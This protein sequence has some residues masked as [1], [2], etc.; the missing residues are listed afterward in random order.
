MPKFSKIVAPALFAAMA[1]GAVSPAMARPTPVR[2][3]TIRSEIVDLQMRV[4]RND[5]RDH[6]SPREAAG[7]RNDVRRLQALYRAYNRNGL[8]P[9]EY[10]TL[11]GRIDNI[12]ERLHI[13][14]H[15]RDNRRW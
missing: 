3:D 11:Q 7:L 13:E 6:I 10:R 15:D 8:S 4:N 9:A 14:R 1:V 2:A 5:R 12:R